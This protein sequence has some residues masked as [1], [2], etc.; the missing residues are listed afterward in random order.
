M[1]QY[2]FITPNRRGKWYDNLRDA[3]ARANAIG[4]GFLDSAGT[5]VLYRGTVLEMREKAIRSA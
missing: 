4:A 3:Q 5:F 1:T 2:R